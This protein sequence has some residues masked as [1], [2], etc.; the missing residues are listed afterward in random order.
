MV[1]TTMLVQRSVYV[2]PAPNAIALILY[3]DIVRHES[4]RSI[5]IIEI[6]LRGSR[7]LICSYLWTTGCEEP[8]FSLRCFNL[9]R[10]CLL[11]YLD[12]A[13]GQVL[14]ITASTVSA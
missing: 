9:T 1:S 12:E 13:P 6:V 8:D 3:A 4:G 14:I 11:L 7:R 5:L 2:Y 10:E